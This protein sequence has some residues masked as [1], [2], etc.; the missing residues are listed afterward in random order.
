MDRAN[1]GREQTIMA[2]TLGSGAANNGTERPTDDEIV[3]VA[4]LLPRW[5]I[6]ALESAATNRGMNMG[7]MLRRMIGATFGTPSPNPAT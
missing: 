6:A 4:L 3:E 5:Q 7:Q 1:R 2:G